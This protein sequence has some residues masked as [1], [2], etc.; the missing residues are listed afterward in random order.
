MALV[1]ALDLRD[2]DPRDQEPEPPAA[3]VIEQGLLG[4]VFYD[5]DA[6]DRLPEGLESRHFYEPFHGRLFK[7]I[8][9]TVAM[10]L[11][12]DPHSL[13]EEFRGD[14]AFEQL[15]GLRYFA[16]LV[17][18][19]PPASQADD[20]GQLV[21]EHSLRRDL[22][23]FGAEIAAAASSINFSEGGAVSVI[24]E[25]ER[26]LLAM[27]TGGL[28]AGLVSLGDA[29]QSLLAYVDDRSAAAV[30]VS[31][32]LAPLDLQ[33]GPML[34]GDLILLAARPSMGKSAIAIAAAL[35]VAA[36]AL[37]A[38]INGRSTFGLAD[39]HGVIVVHAEMTWG[40]K[41]GGQAV[42]RHVSDVGY[43]LYGDE[44]PSYRDL[45]DKKVSVSQREMIVRVMELLKDIPILGIKRTG[46]TL[47]TL[48]SLVRR[49]G[50]AWARIGQRIGLVVI[51]H[52]GLIRWEGKGSGRY[53]GQTEIAIG[54]K[55]MAGEIEAPIMAL[56]QLNRGV[57]QR[58]D[59]QPVLSDLRDSGAWEENADAVIMPFRK[60]YYAQREKEP[61]I[62]VKQG[63]ANAEWHAAKN[64]KDID[65]L[66]PKLREGEAGGG[67]KVWGALAWNAIRG[68]EPERV[69]TGVLFG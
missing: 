62:S 31:T 25:A 46:L 50:A 18:R 57:E 23:K 7:R 26:Q 28:K 27:H 58:D 9:D 68:A 49:Q 11:T 44:F 47:A 52:V 37:A 22:I 29:T 17:D 10:G 40:D 14:P 61:D 32:G 42:R 12:A 48:R 41:T 53:E 59:K 20:F 2:A 43:A 15:G 45:R 6:L 63:I 8:R 36:P 21:I 3:L 34:P 55:E 51:D 54:L 19:S 56:A 65:L 38:E 33:L 69:N 1:P 5:N 66:M 60:A 39:A 24:A 16:D 35:G 4:I 13:S 64:S 67:A 30:G